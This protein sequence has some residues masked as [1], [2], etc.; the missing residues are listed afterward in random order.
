MKNLGID[1]ILKSFSTHSE[2]QV[3]KQIGILKQIYDQFQEDNGDSVLESTVDES[4]DNDSDPYEKIVEMINSDDEDKKY[5]AVTKIFDLAQHEKHRVA[6]RKQNIFDGLIN[7]LTSEF[8]ETLEDAAGAI[9]QLALD[10]V[11]SEILGV[12][13]VI[14]FLGRLLNIEDEPHIVKNSLFALGNLAF[15]NADNR[16][17]MNSKKIIKSLGKIIKKVKKARKPVL[18]VLT[19]LAHDDEIRDNLLKYGVVDSVVALLESDKQD[20]KLKAVSVLWNLNNNEEIRE[21]LYEDEETFNIMT[22]LLPEINMS[23]MSDEY[24]PIPKEEQKLIEKARKNR[25]KMEN[26]DAIEEVKKRDEQKT[27]VGYS[28][29]YNLTSFF[30]EEEE[31]EEEYKP[32]ESSDE[33]PEEAVE[34]ES[35]EEPEE[36]IEVEESQLQNELN[37]ANEEQIE[38]VSKRDRRTRQSE[39]RKTKVMA[40]IEKKKL[41]MEEKKQEKLTEIKKEKEEQEKEDAKKKK[42][43]EKIR[44]I[45][46]ELRSTEK[47]YVESLSK[48]R[49]LYMD[50][51]VT[52]HAGIITTDQFKKIFGDVIEAMIDSEEFWKNVALNV[53][54][55]FLEFASTFKM[56][57]TYINNYDD[58]TDQVHRLMAKNKKFSEFL[59]N[60]A[61]TLEN[62]KF[63]Q[64]DLD[65]LLIVPIQR[66]PRYKLLTEDLLK[67]VE[68]E[69]TGHIVL[70]GAIEQIQMV[71]MA[72][73]EKKREIESDNAVKQLADDLKWP[74]LFIPDRTMEKEL[75]S[76][77][78][79]TYERD[80]PTTTKSKKNKCLFYIL[81]DL[82]IIV[83]GKKASGKNANLFSLHKTA[84]PL[85]KAAD[86]DKEGK[87]FTMVNQNNI[88]FEVECDTKS[89]RDETMKLIIHLIQKI[90]TEKITKRLSMRK[91]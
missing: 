60:A 91:K 65:S 90:E 28:N 29:A 10:H 75:R 51:L 19:S 61:L 35:D 5:T 40:K 81:T 7:C 69:S 47:S 64:K 3:K 1:G 63:R 22:E 59:Q 68:P 53:G 56:Y 42:K 73:N 38:E 71:T 9:S 62:L 8:G 70:Q 86:Q 49:K 78:F 57:Q 85:Q 43:Q 30:E 89:L 45:V 11:N 13:G 14:P 17:E 58:Q 18:D 16:A 34:I 50:P 23:S 83:K 4:I 72:C 55:L 12:K 32:E 66:L 15:K 2:P 54:N 41:K 6:F 74:D 44:F 48:I 52:T 87:C 24:A 27:S 25:R 80:K 46:N 67:N 21:Y 84:K 37:E 82:V 39:L 76:F 20:L 77:S 31:E 79:V 26:L 88:V 33:E 36:A